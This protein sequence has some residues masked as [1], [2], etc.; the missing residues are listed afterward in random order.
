VKY[1]R[2]QQGCRVPESEKWGWWRWN[3]S[4]SAWSTPPHHHSPRHSC[5]GPPLCT[6]SAVAWL[7][8]QFSQLCLEPSQ[9]GCQ[10]EQG[11]SVPPSARDKNQRNHQ[12]ARGDERRQTR[13][14]S[15]LGVTLTPA[16]ASKVCWRLWVQA[17]F[18]G[19]S[20]Q[21]Q[22]WWN[23]LGRVAGF[24]APRLPFHPRASSTAASWLAGAAA[25]QPR[26]LSPL[27]VHGDV[28]CERDSQGQR[29]GLIS[30]VLI[31]AGSAHAGDQPF[32]VSGFTIS[33][34]PTNPRLGEK[35]GSSVTESPAASPAPLA[36][37]L[38]EA[39]GAWGTPSDRSQPRRT[40]TSPLASRI[41][42]KPQ[43][44]LKRSQRR[45]HDRPRR[46]QGGEGLQ[47]QGIPP[48]P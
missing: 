15:G 13:T 32:P 43:N 25:T 46:G 26:S 1:S 48:L 20:L 38:S 6:G 47:H 22:G 35:P 37:A 21:A 29:F 11:V 33:V 28:A 30:P 45:E 31:A 39:A 5:P 3:K 24:K 23:S 36:I 18:V 41:T 8:C 17:T 10:K 40:Q 7:L 19:L 16:P 34:R 14:R 42:T 9:S 12:E 44:N 4:R 2:S 27:S